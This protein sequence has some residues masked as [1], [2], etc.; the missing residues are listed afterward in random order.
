MEKHAFDLTISM[1]E[2]RM[3]CPY[4][5]KDLKEIHGIEGFADAL[6]HG[7]PVI[8]MFHFCPNCSVLLGITEGL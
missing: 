1:P 2:K 3:K 8:K 6:E 4:C 7:T 5:K